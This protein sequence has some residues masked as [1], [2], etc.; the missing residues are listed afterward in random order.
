MGC[1]QV[2]CA[3]IAG[4]DACADREEMYVQDKGGMEDACAVGGGVDMLDC[5]W[6]P[7]NRKKQRAC[8]GRAVAV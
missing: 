4:K 7:E 1:A 5:G 6:T 8:L 2:V 3:R